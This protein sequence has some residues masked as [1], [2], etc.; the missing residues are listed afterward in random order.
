M[1]FASKLTEIRKSRN[2]T[3]QELAEKVGVGISQMRRYEK[4]SSSPTLEVIKNLALSLG[5]S[6]DELIFETSERI[7][8]SRILDRE[9]LRQ[10]ETVSSLTPRDIDAIKTVLES[11]I[12][13]NRIEEILPGQSKEHAWEED[14]RIVQKKFRKKAADYS[15]QEIEDLINEAV[16]DVRSEKK[17]PK[18]GNS[19][20]A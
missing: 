2:L 20:G 3:Q 19:I 17:S 9:L 6:S 10:F 5:V 12:I 11:I 13:K 8:A 1:A 4:G 15:G 18:K 7:A 16:S 14:M